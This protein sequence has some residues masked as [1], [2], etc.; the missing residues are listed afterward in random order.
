M[1]YSIITS[2]QGETATISTQ[3]LSINTSDW[4][5]GIYFVTV[6]GDISGG[7]LGEPNVSLSAKTIK[8]VKR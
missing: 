5:S 1:R 2:P 3:S 4:A 8:I 6:F 7:I